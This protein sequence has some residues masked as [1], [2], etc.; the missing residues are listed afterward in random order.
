M[1]YDLYCYRSRIGKPDIDEARVA[2]EQVESVDNPES[3][4]NKL[5]VAKALTD[6]N[7]RLEMFDLDYEEISKFENISIDEVHERYDYIELN[8]PEGDLAIQITINNNNVILTIP[9]WYQNKQAEQVFKDLAEYLKTIRRTVGYFV[10]DPQIDKA[11]DPLVTEVEGIDVYL[12]TTQGK[13]STKPW[14]RF[15]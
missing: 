14:W 11:F 13:N 12:Q 4:Q 10:Y 7:P 5:R 8:S 2:I 6:Y 3:K 1:S 9:Y 15:W